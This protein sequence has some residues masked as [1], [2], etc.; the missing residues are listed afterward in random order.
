MVTAAELVLDLP[1]RRGDKVWLAGLTTG[2]RMMRRQCTVT[3]ATSAITIAPAHVPRFRAVHEE[4]CAPPTHCRA[5]S[6]P[7]SITSRS[8]HRHEPQSYM[9]LT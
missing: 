6:Q 8:S 5:S 7:R 2:H 9:P 1:L 4:V 3:T